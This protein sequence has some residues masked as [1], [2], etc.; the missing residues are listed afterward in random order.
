MNSTCHILNSLPFDTAVVHTVLSQWDMSNGTK[1]ELSFSVYHAALAT[2]KP[3]ERRA[4]AIE[5]IHVR[6]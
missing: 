6:K 2:K 3:G 4:N 5:R 1:A